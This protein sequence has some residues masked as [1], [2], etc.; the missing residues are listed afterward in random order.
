MK[1]LIV[2]LISIN[3]CLVNAGQDGPGCIQFTGDGAKK[4]FLELYPFTQGRAT[5]IS[6]ERIGDRISIKTLNILCQVK[7]TKNI[8]NRKNTTEE[9]VEVFK[10]IKSTDFECGYLVYSDGGLKAC[11]GAL[12]P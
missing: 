1:N 2:L 4:T 6:A 8:P 5:A 7:T 12:N 3:S 9:N 11:K 10:K